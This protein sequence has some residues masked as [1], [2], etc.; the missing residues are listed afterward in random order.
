MP[1]LL[2]LSEAGVRWK[3]GH[4]GHLGGI[5]DSD[6]SVGAAQAVERA[7]VAAGPL[8]SRRVLDSTLLSVE[9]LLVRGGVCARMKSPS[10]PYS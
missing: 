4:L 1:S 2:S 7:A 8:S 6:A 10:G 3:T 5:L 9:H